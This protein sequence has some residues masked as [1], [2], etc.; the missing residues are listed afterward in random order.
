LYT[1]TSESVYLFF[2]K[3]RGYFAMQGADYSPYHFHGCTHC[4]LQKDQ[5]KGQC[6]SEGR[7]L[8]FF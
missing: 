3:K 8:E 7:L 4:L 5:R 6:F 1:F 2:N